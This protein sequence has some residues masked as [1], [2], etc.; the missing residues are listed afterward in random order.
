MVHGLVVVLSID[1]IEM[2]D[3]V[4]ALYTHRVDAGHRT[5]DTGH[6]GLVSYQDNQWSRRLEELYG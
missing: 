6:I 5:Q 3:P 4:R 2:I 1:R